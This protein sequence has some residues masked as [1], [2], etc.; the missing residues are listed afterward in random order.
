[1][2]ERRAGSVFL[3]NQT[4]SGSA[5]SDISV[6]DPRTGKPLKFDYLSGE[7]LAKDGTPGRFDPAEH[8]IRARLAGAVPEGGEGRVKI[9]KT[10]KRGSSVT[11]RLLL[12]PIPCV[13]P[14]RQPFCHP[15]LRDFWT[16]ELLPHLCRERIPCGEDRVA[17]AHRRGHRRAPVRPAIEQQVCVP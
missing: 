5:G 9:P 13:W 10:Y 14:L 15:H 17:P 4:R 6:F 12:N 7:E 1:M 2:T 3:L 8:Y 16:P 11:D